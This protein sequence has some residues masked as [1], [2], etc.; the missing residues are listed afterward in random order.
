MS[1]SEKDTFN[2]MYGKDASFIDPT[3]M[4]NVAKVMNQKFLDRK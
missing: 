2:R 3:N 1:D 4:M